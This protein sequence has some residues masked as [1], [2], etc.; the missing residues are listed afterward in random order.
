MCKKSTNERETTEEEEKKKKEEEEEEEE[1]QEPQRRV[2]HDIYV[3]ESDGGEDGESSVYINVRDM[4]ALTSVVN[5]VTLLTTPKS[6]VGELLQEVGRRFKYEPDS[7]TLILQRVDGEEIEVDKVEPEKSLG[8]AG[9]RVEGAQRNNLVLS[10]QGGVPPRRTDEDDLSLG[11]SASPTANSAEK[12][13]FERSNNYENPPEYS[14]SSALI[15]QE[16]GYIGLVNQAMTCYLNSLLQTLFM[17][18]EFRNALYRWEFKGSEEEASK[19]IPCQLQRLFLMLQTAN[20]S[21][22]ET[23][24]LTRSFGWDS[25]EAW[26][27]HDIQ[28]LCRVMFDALE[29]SFKNT[30]QAD[31]INRLYEGKMKDYVKCLECGY[32]SAREDT[33]LDIPLPI[34]PF[35]S[36][37]AY[38]SVEEALKHFVEPE[39]LTGNNKY[40]CSKCNNLCDAHKGL[41]FTR[42]PYL[43]TIHLKRF[44]FDYQTLHRIKLNDKVTFPNVLDLNNFIDCASENKEEKIES[45]THVGQEKVAQDKPDDASTSDSG[46]ATIDGED[47]SIEHTHVPPHP[48]EN[49]DEDEGIDVSSMY[50]EKNKTCLSSGPFVYDLFSIMV[51]SGSASGGHYYAYIKDLTTG[52]WYCFNDQSVSR[53]TYDDIRKTYGGGSSRGYYSNWSSSA[54]AYMLMYRQIDKEKNVDSFTKEHFPKH[55]TELVQRMADEEAAEREAREMERSMCRIKLFCQH[56]TTKHMMEKKLRIHKDTTLRET[57]KL[58]YEE[59]ELEG[60][61]PLER[62][63]LVKYEEVHDSLECSFDGQDDELISEILGGVRSSYKFDLL[64]EVRDEDKQFEVYKPGGTTVKVHLIDLQTEEVEGPFTVRGS[65]SMTVREFKELLGR[66]FSL[67]PDT[68]RVV[69]ERYYNG[70]KLLTGDTKALKLE[71]FYRSS[72]VYVEASGIEPNDFFTGS[73]MYHIMDRFE[74]TI[75]LHCSLPDTS[76]DALAELQIPAY[77]EENTEA[78]ASSSTYTTCTTASTTTSTSVTSSA[79]SLPTISTAESASITTTSSTTIVTTT[80]TTPSDSTSASS[81]A[82]SHSKESGVCSKASSDTCS[83]SGS[84]VTTP[85]TAAS[86]SVGAASDGEDEGIVD[87]D[88]GAGSST[89]NSDQSASEDSSL[90]SDSDRTLVGDPPE[91]KLSDTSSSPDY[92]NVSSPEDNVKDSKDQTNSTVSGW[93]EFE[94]DKE[95]LPVKRYFRAQY[96][97]DHETNQKMLRVYVDKRITFGQLKMEMQPWV[98][99]SQEHFKFFK[100]YSISQEFECTRMSETLA[101]YGDNARLTVR[102]GRALLPGEQRG[103]VYFL[104]LDNPDDPAKFLIDWVICKGDTVAN[105]KRAVVKEANQRCQLDLKVENVR[106]RKKSWKNPQTIYLDPQKFED[107]IPLYSNWELFLQVIE[108]P[109]TKTGDDDELSI[110]VKRWRPSSFTTDPVSEIVIPE[111]TSESL[112]E[113]LSSISGIAVDNVEFA[114]GQ[115][116][117]PFDMPVVSINQDLDWI[118]RPGPLDSRPLYISED[119]ALVYYRDK[120]EKEKELSEDERRELSNSENRRLNRDL[121]YSCPGSS[122]SGH[123]TLR[124]KEKGLR[125]YLNH[126]PTEE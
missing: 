30:D 124:S 59:L 3:D 126:N 10:D 110:F 18:P 97:T 123:S 79:P 50:N 87:P 40:K 111:A 100:S 75:T 14:Y 122:S 73:S 65:L 96:Y 103:K 121:Q 17:T 51:H 38:Q 43:L 88:S 44:D 63:R 67:N 46:L 29:L 120:T 115:G 33:Y 27:Q 83:Q 90:T 113:K 22:V 16:T 74:N 5:R 35:G 107:N 31:L 53:I 32:E 9:F 8:E 60:V 92:R 21:A 104:E 58:A 106:L 109:E 80:T 86:T 23:T 56:P 15:K 116:T 61:V 70:L 99:V 98:G 2:T 54:N 26:Q 12:K 1:Q 45:T 81:P 78:G 25:S 11:A 117:F 24:N 47:S 62:C 84:S 34:R 48:H 55:I 125:I 66:H 39:V 114:K 64:M 102:L 69:L 118:Q 82:S 52:E 112:R 49:T 105:V 13:W 94:E 42:F 7:F 6:T 77:K 108:G 37:S 36:S 101:S 89:V 28:E 20:K 95:D 91:D 72:K 68:M 76:S 85:S 93:V 119:G 71:G 4:S 57:V 19:N 41:K